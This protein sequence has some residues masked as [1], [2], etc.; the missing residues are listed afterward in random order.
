M[1]LKQKVPCIEQAGIY[2]FQG[3]GVVSEGDDRIA[4]GVIG[5]HEISE[6]RHAC[7]ITQV[8]KIAP[9]LKVRNRVTVSYTHLTLPTKA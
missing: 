3:D 5:D 1:P 7:D 2:A 9:I 8:N 6:A 4:I